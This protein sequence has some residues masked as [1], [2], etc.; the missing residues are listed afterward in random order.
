[1][2]CMTAIPLRRITQLPAFCGPAS[3][4]MMLSQHGVEVDQQAIATATN[5]TDLEKDGTR[6]DQLA[7]AVKTLAPDYRMWAKRNATLWDVDVLIHTRRYVVGVEWQGLWTTEQLKEMGDSGDVNADD[8]GH[9]S[10]ITGI[11]MKKNTLVIQDPSTYYAGTR[12]FTFEAFEKRWF[13]T[14][15]VGSDAPEEAK[16]W[17]D[18]YHVLF[19]VAPKDSV[20]PEALQL[21]KVRM[22]ELK[23]TLE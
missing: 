16:E 3:L 23:V 11:D 15:K 7:R 18:D 1:M 14:N 4:A 10:V 19:I 12:E 8:L 21:K 5:A 22:K 9:Y 6:I 13:D 17:M 20:F 2:V